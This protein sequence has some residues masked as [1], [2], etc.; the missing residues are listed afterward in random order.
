MQIYI[1][2]RWIS[3]NVNYTIGRD[4]SVVMHIL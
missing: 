1:G 3:Y 4:G 2:K